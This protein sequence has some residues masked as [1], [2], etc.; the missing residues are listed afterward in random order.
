MRLNHRAVGLHAKLMLALALVVVLLAS[1]STYVLVERER[2]RRLTELEGRA[3]RIA[4]LFSRSLAQPLSNLDRAAIGNQLA[5]LAPNP[6]VLS[7]RVTAP[8]QGTV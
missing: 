2:E 3:T 1:A 7:F 6:E 5:A 4:E 8:G